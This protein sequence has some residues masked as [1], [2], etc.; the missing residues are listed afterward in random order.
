MNIFVGGVILEIVDMFQYLEANIHNEADC[1][2]DI[3]KR[4]A[5]ASNLLLILYTFWK[6]NLSLLTPSEGLSNPLYGQ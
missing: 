1:Y 2:M 3:R 4:W 5:V 6:L